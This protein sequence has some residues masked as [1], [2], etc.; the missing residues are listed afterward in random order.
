MV[1]S[2]TCTVR[3]KKRVQATSFSASR[4]S[5]SL[6]LWDNLISSLRTQQDLSDIV[7]LS[8]I[9]HLYT[10]HTLVSSLRTKQDLPDIVHL[11]HIV[12]L[13]TWHTLVSSLRT[14]QDLS[15]IIYLS[16]CLLGIP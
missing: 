11:S 8:H 9:V 1:S 16:T 10:W 2:H 3:W 15:D 12:H 5:G 4:L 6:V 13:Y 14:Q 7:H